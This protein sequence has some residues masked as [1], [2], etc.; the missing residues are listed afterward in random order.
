MD[1]LFIEIILISHYLLI[2]CEAK[3][4]HYF[5]VMDEQNIRLHSE[6]QPNYYIDGKF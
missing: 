5:I 2:G 6:E 4:A 1:V 3:P